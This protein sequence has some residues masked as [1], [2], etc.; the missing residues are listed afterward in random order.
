LQQGAENFLTKPVDLPLLQLAAERGLEKAALR[1]MS[2]FISERRG[3]AAPVLLG[4]SPAMRELQGQIEVLAQSGR[5]TGLII[6]ESGTGKGRVAELI[7]RLSPRAGAPFVEVNCAALTE[8]SLESEL[9]GR[10]R[11]DGGEVKPGLIEVADG[12]TLFLDEIGDLDPHLQ[13][14]LIRLLEGKGFRRAGGTAEV[15]ADVRVL[16]ATSKDL[17]AAVAAG[18]FREDLYYRLSVVPV[19]LP[20]LRTRTREDLVELIAHLREELVPHLPDAPHQIGEDALERLLRYGWPGNIRELRNVLERAML[21][22]RRSD[23]IA[24][25]HLP[26]EVRGATGARVEH[27]APRSLEDVERAH[28]DRTLRAHQFNRTHTAKE[29]GIS[30]ATLIKK[31]RQYSLGPAGAR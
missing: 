12:G 23:R 28:I 13:P 9:F 5:T 18:R 19:A 2:R 8:D 4:S 15:T 16:A 26:A 31:I 30:R 14:K 17:G 27:H 20:P 25:E 29:L 11:G 21:L 3:V 22:A 7:H 6:G 24:A 10:E 1:R